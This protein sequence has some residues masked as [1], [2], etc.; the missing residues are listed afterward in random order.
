MT[1][2]QKVGA[3]SG[4]TVD[5]N[6]IN[7]SRAQQAVERLQM[8]I[9]KAVRERRWGK[10]RA[11]QWLL[12]RSFYGRTIAVKRVTENQGKDTPGVDREI[13]NT[14]RRKAGAILSL[15]RRGYRPSP[16]RRV[17]IPKA[18]GKQRPLGIPTMR[19]RAMQ[20][21]HLLALEPIAETTADRNSFG[22]RP[23]RASRDAAEHCFNALRLPSCAQ[24]VLDADISGCF[25]NI[26]HEWLLANIPMDKAILRKWLKSG[27]V[28]KGRM[29][30]TP[31]GT[32]QGG[33]VSPTLANMTLDGLEKLLI[34]HFGDKN[35][36][37]ARRAKVNLVRYADDF[38]VTGASK[39][40]LE[41]AKSLIVPFLK[42]RGLSLSEEKTRITHID[43][44]FD[45]LGWNFRKYKG[46]L[47]IQPAKKNV[48]AVLRKVR[49]IIKTHRAAKQATVI[50]KLNPII[51]GW[52]NYHRN[53]VAHKTFAKVD[54]DIW[55]KLWRWMRRRHPGKSTK[56]MTKRYFI[57]EGRR[58]WVFAAT[59]TDDMGA[60][61]VFRL[62]RATD[63]P[64][65]R[66]IKI[67][68]EATPYDPKWERY[69]MKRT[70]KSYGAT[71]EIARPSSRPRDRRTTGSFRTEL[72]EA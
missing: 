21:L 23:K 5:W 54:N 26:S 1:T 32:P 13:W 59:M 64:I 65:R 35:R 50:A 4:R 70:V 2:L 67:R 57:R 12:T 34:A 55:W 36:R 56:W 18:N 42:E 9:A 15:R 69:F 14:S 11:L 45:F 20:A 8:R 37:K 47:L 51:W 17:F 71:A 30:P 31:A 68:G 58:N 22:F 19:D 49:E 16:L 24:W 6:G 60:R 66:H 29:F 46:K 61:K 25:D 48:Q 10:A 72:T 40:V 27:F 38:I 43:D 41:E 62:A 28:W 63:T 7:W 53:Q 3:A 52:A 39:E 33:I 44:G